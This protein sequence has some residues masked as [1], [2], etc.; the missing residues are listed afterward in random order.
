MTDRD[1]TAGP[2]RPA[3]KLDLKKV[4]EGMEL[5]FEEFCREHPDIPRDE[6]RKMWE[7]AGG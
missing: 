3:A 6:A 2:A 7:A 4:L 1:E 5:A